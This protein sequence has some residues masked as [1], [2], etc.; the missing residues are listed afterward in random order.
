MSDALTPVAAIDRDALNLCLLEQGGAF[1]SALSER[2]DHLFA[3]VALCVTPEQVAQMQ[4][5]IAA[6]EAIVS[7][8]YPAADKQTLGVCYGY[9][10][11]LN[12]DGAHLIEINTNA[13]GAFLNAMLIDSQRETTL[14]GQALADEGLEQTFVAMF[15]NEWRL[16]RGDA[17]LH[18]IAIVDESPVEQYLYP[19]FVL[20]KNLLQRDGIEVFIVDPAELLA[21]DDGLYVDEVRIDLIYNRLTDFSLRQFPPLLAAY[22]NHQ[23]VFTPN[24]AHYRCY[25]DKR[26]L[27]SFSDEHFLQTAGVAPIHVDALLR[28]V[29]Q[30]KLVN[31]A[32][33]ETWWT[34]RKQWFFK[35]VSGYGSKG[36]YRGDKITKRVFEDIMQS[37][38]VAQRLAMPGEC[39]VAGENGES[40][41]LKYDVRC[42]VYDGH[43]QLV[44]ARLYQGQTT[45]FR[46]SGGGFAMLRVL[47]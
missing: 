13:G 28:G 46:T 4:A 34:E 47:G 20:A 23:A 45:N 8:E 5:V 25:A 37:D 16:A 43:I 11:H 27:V 12:G 1:A 44:A 41:A 9:D 31:S 33:A 6:V 7:R 26:K 22:E 2:H 18:T 39:L 10:F 24:P 42:Y 21:R 17:P 36:A 35:P 29:P 32:D 14:P 30:T 15:R 38:Y 40:R 19:E 3:E